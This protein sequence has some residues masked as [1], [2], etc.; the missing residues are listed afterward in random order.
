MLLFII[1]LSKDGPLAFMPES[2]RIADGDSV[3]EV[4]Q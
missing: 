1:H 3:H 4:S 2:I